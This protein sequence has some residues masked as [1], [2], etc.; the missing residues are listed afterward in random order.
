MWEEVAA[1]SSRRHPQGEP[2]GQGVL[3]D[4][5]R[6]VAEGQ[7]GFGAEGLE[8]RTEAVGGDFF[9]SVPAGGD[10]YT[11]K[12]IIHDWDDAQSLAILKNCHRAMPRGSRLLLVESVIPPRNEP[13]LGKFMDS[14]HARDDRRTRTDRRRVPHFLAAAGFRLTRVVATPSPVS[15]IEA[16]RGR[17]VKKQ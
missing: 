1:A 15:V 11:L 16:A 3:F 9:E 2:D 8:G 10:I 13:S 14:E 7:A 4:A 17:R 5:P 12:W 6:V